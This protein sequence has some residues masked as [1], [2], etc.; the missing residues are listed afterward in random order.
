MAKN[1]FKLWY[2]LL[3]SL[4]FE[5]S[6][7][8]ICELHLLFCVLSL[9]RY[10]VI[11]AIQVIILTWCV[12]DIL[13]SLCSVMTTTIM[14]STLDEPT[15][16]AVLSELLV[17]RCHLRLWKCQLIIYS[18]GKPPKWRLIAG[19]PPL[20]SWAYPQHCRSFE[21]LIISLFTLFLLSN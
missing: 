21:N 6:F 18:G 3:R 2:L 10:S 19:R 16:I 14:M 11:L 8:E 17:K 9:W 12:I 1:Y 15:K 5:L 4:A 20:I 7:T 13:Q